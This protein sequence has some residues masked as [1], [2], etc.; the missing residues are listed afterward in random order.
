MH[1]DLRTEILVLF[2]E[3]TVVSTIFNSVSLCKI[4]FDCLLQQSLIVSCFRQ[5]TF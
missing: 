1:T 5:G 2:L 4:V 3:I